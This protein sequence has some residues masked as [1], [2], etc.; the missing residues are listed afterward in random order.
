MK[1]KQRSL[2]FQ[3]SL[4][5]ALLTLAGCGSSVAPTGTVTG[6][7]TLGGNPLTTGVVTLVNR[8]QGLGASSELDASGKYQ[9]EAVPTGQY[10]VVIQGP[11]APSPEEMDEGAKIEASSVPPKYQAAETSGLSVEIAEG[12]NQADF[13]L[14]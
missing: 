5:T 4:A 7:V 14:Q 11:E 12:K 6:Q 2:M 10:Q 8:D 9:I 1:V 13:E 3:W